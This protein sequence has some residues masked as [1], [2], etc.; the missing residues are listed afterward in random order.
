MKNR[1][2]PS[3][4][5]GKN[6]E[7]PDEP[8]GYF[9]QNWRMGCVR[10]RSFFERKAAPLPQNTHGDD[11]VHGAQHAAYRRKDP[12][13]GILKGA[14]AEVGDDEPADI[15]ERMDGDAQPDVL[16]DA[17]HHAEHD[18]EQKRISDLQRRCAET[19]AEQEVEEVRGAEQCGGDEHGEAN[20]PLYAPQA[21]QDGG[22]QQGAEEQLLHERHRDTF[23]QKQP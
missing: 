13:H 20:I 3:R 6:E 17:E 11:D 16:R 21:A 19:R 12:E 9:L 18:P 15:E 14:Y 7:P 23:Q 2:T 5:G 4:R 22:E 8:T 1:P 10:V